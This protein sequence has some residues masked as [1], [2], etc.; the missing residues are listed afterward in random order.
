MIGEGEE[1]CPGGTCGR[2]A[3]GKAGRI[4]LH[5]RVFWVFCG[6]EIYMRSAH[7]RA[8]AWKTLTS[9]ELASRA[10]WHHPLSQKMSWSPQTFTVLDLK[11]S[12]S[13]F[14]VISHCPF[15]SSVAKVLWASIKMSSSALECSETVLPT[16]L[17]TACMCVSGG[18]PLC[19]TL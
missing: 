11:K 16:I 1:W 12:F 19:Y 9:V 17:T 6:D 8:K 13:K 10:R 15:P 4:S 3:V 2:C 18:L 14:Q 7:W 5:L